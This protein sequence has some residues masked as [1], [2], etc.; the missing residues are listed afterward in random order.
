VYTAS[1]RYS[2]AT[3]SPTAHS[4]TSVTV[5]RPRHG[6]VA[7]DAVGLVKGPHAGMDVA[8]IPQRQALAVPRTEPPLHPEH[9]LKAVERLVVPADVVVGPRC[10]TTVDS[11]CPGLDRDGT[12]ER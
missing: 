7:P 10:P 2:P 8:E 5:R 4:V 6:G 9:A 11:Q 3:V 1:T 12:A